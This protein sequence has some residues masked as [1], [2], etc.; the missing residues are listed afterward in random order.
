MLVSLGRRNFCTV[1]NAGGSTAT[2]LERLF[3]LHT[4]KHKIPYFECRSG[5]IEILKDPIDFY[6]TLHVKSQLQPPR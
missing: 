6:I 3:N 4:K 2:N 1:S 5:N